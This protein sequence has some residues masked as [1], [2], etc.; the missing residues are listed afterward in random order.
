M[1]F[2]CCVWVDEWDGG[3]GD[4]GVGVCV[5]VYECVCVCVRVYVCVRVRARVCVCRHVDECIILIIE[6]QHRSALLSVQI[7]TA[8]PLAK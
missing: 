2:L 4:V 5:C 7:S 1:E 8:F 6:A 3:V